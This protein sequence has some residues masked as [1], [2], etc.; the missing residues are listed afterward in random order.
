MH[1]GVPANSSSRYLHVQG[2]KKMFYLSTHSSHVIYDYMVN[3]NSDNKRKN[4]LPP[5]TE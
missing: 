4:P 5:Q 1:A 2:R 3:D